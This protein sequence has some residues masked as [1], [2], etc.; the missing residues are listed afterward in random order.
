MILDAADRTNAPTFHAF[1]SHPSQDPSVAK[2][3]SAAL[4]SRR[5][6]S[7]LHSLPYLYILKEGEHDE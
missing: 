3:V 7:R 1:L 5:L 2:E 6:T 4:E